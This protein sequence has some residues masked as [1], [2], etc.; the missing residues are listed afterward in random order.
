MLLLGIPLLWQSIR[1]TE[2]ALKTLGKIK[3]PTKKE[4]KEI[5]IRKQQLEDL[6]IELNSLISPF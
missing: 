4:L 3:E 6:N 5:R 1:E 2:Q